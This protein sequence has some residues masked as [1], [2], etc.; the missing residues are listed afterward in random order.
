MRLHNY[1]ATLSC[2]AVVSAAS[3]RGRVLNIAEHNTAK[4][5]EQVEG[6]PRLCQ[7]LLTSTSARMVVRGPGL[8][9]RASPGAMGHTTS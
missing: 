4:E 5:C 6:D 8:L 7:G 2:K 3:Y 1:S 9:R